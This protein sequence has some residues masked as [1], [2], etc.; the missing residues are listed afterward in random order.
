MAQAGDKRLEAPDF[1]DFP[2]GATFQKKRIC[3]LNLAGK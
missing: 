1:I 3:L 2:R